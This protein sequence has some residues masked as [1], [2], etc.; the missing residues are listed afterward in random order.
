MSKITGVYDAF[1]ARVKALL[2]NHLQLSDPYNFLKNTASEYRQGFG[3]RV[4]PG[5]NTGEILS[6]NLILRQ[7]FDL[8]ITRLVTARE[9]ERDNKA[10]IEKSLLEDLFLIINDTESE[11]TLA[12]SSVLGADFVSHSGIEF[13]KGDRDDILSII[14][15]FR[16]RYRENLDA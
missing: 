8:V 16:I 14:A 13:V 10:V 11:P 5:E 12:S 7:N 2:P 3:V 15:S 1:V 9:T 4:G 6:C